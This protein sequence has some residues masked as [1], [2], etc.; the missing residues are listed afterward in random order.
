MARVRMMR[1]KKRA[2]EQADEWVRGRAVSEGE[3]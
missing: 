3:G 1:P 2:V